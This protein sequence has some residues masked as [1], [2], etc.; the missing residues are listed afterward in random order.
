MAL[1]K[2][3]DVLALRRLIQQQGPAREAAFVASLAA[4]VA[5]LYDRVIATS[6][7]P[8][9]LQSAL[10]EE[11]ARFLYPGDADGLHRLGRQLAQASYSRIY[12]AFLLFPTVEYVVGRAA[13]LWRAYYDEGEAEVQR[14][15]PRHLRFRL[16]YFPEFPRPLR[17][18]LVSHM[19]VLLEATG[20]KDVRISE[21]GLVEGV[22]SWS[23]QWS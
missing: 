2:G 6:W 16:S 17:T 3:S 10:Y 19:E 14:L 21:E 1:T 18:F 5:D 12:R 9:T 22:W 20:A 7:S 8:V 4:S 23:L 13:R 11:A 15:G